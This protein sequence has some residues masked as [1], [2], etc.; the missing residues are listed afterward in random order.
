MLFRSVR[1]SRTNPRTAGIDGTARFITETEAGQTYFNAQIGV[2]WAISELKQPK[3]NKTIPLLKS[4]VKFAPSTRAY[5]PVKIQLRAYPKV[6]RG[7][8]FIVFLAPLPKTL[9]PALKAA[10]ITIKIIGKKPP[11]PCPT[12]AKATVITPIRQMAMPTSDFFGV[13]SLRKW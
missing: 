13:A 5:P 8:K 12:F 7:K 3:K 4:I 10:A 1:R 11:K 2:L 9:L 6:I